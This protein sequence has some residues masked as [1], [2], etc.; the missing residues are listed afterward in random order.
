MAQAIEKLTKTIGEKDMQ[1]ALLINSLTY[2][3][4][5]TKKFDNLRMPTKYQPPKFLQFNGIVLAPMSIT[6]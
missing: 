6:S 5:Y 3:K 4:L 2:S 1:I